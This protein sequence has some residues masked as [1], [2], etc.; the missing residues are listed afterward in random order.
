MSFWVRFNR[1]FVV[2]DRNA[3]KLQLLV[4]MAPLYYLGA[5]KAQ[6]RG[7]GTRGGGASVMRGVAVDTFLVHARLLCRV[8]VTW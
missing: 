3:I 5:E 6:S 2:L 4:A 7:N 1:L 8:E